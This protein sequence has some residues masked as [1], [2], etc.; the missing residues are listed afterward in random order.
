M[1][2]ASFGS[3]TA[4][5]ATPDHEP[6]VARSG[7][8]T[9]QRLSPSTAA[10]NIAAYVAKHS[11]TIRRGPRGGRRQVTPGHPTDQLDLRVL[12]PHREAFQ[13]RK[14]LWRRGGDSNP[15]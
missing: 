7:P 6:L 3:A 2:R 11:V 12:E 14:V 5:M 10:P 15:R 9:P 4:A 8:P 1:S 13:Q